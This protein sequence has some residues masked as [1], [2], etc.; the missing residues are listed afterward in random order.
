[1]KGAFILKI[2]MKI[3]KNRISHLLKVYSE[4]RATKAE[5]QNLF[6]WVASRGKEVPIKK[7]IDELVS[8]YNPDQVLPTVD[9]EH[10][11]KNIIETKNSR[12]SQPAIL[13]KITWRRWAAAAAAAITLGTGFYFVNNIH[14]GQKDLLATGLPKK[15]DIA[16][17]NS[18]NAVL[19]LSD[20]QKI[21]LDSTGNGVL[22][23]QGSVNVV[24]LADGK[25]AYRGASN[26]IQYNTL[27]N[28]RGSKV[29]NLALADGSRVWLNTASSLR[30]PTA[31]S[32]S[33]RKVEIT[34]EAYLEVAH[35]PDMP[36][37]VSKGN[38]N[39]KVLGTRFNVNAYDDESTLDVTLLEGSV[40]VAAKT[41]QRPSIIKAGEQAAVNKNGNIQVNYSVDLDDVMAWKN[42][43]F[44]FKG[45]DIQSVMKEVSR[46]YDVNVI[47]DKA[48]DEKF[49]ADVSR[50]TSV[51]TLLAMLEAT[52]AVHFKIEGRTINVMP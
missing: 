22:A 2:N 29:I 6:E 46:W 8:S 5:E 43:I 20:G 14:K 21:I 48:G 1:M 42:E 25:I 15:N 39:I 27:S 26:E 45:D 47:F 31:F 50:N 19:I 17:P 51:S 49:Y 23:K 9:W 24:K 40:S 41:D 34:G 44:S 38:T 13:R 52:K 18:V 4:G 3:S 10:L 33:E 12:N 35:N 28:P 11:Y 36:F 16:A 30:F 32:G 7:H 37:V